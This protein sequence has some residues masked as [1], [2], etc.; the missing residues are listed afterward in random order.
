MKEKI[1]DAIE[2]TLV[3][4]NKE[5]FDKYTWPKIEKILADHGLIQTGLESY[6]DNIEHK[7]LNDKDEEVNPPTETIKEN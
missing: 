2:T 1:K 3:I 6:K 5:S 7:R 4:Y